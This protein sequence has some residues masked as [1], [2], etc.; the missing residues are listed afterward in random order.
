M[1]KRSG[2]AQETDMQFDQLENRLR[3]NLSAELIFP[4]ENENAQFG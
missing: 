2:N 3:G 4:A 1:A